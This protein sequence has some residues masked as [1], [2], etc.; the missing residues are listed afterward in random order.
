MNLGSFEDGVPPVYN[1]SAWDAVTPAQFFL[2]GG[3]G[4]GGAGAD[5]HG[6]ARHQ[7]DSGIG[8]QLNVDFR[9]VATEAIVSNSVTPPAV[10]HSTNLTY[11][12]FVD[13]EAFSLFS[14]E[15]REGGNANILLTSIAKPTSIWEVF[16]GVALGDVI[17]SVL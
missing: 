2:V 3:T 13:P 16:S 9:N 8:S 14:R 1:Y 6:I 15:L 4:G 5:G 11:P 10:S 7:K 17:S 12:S